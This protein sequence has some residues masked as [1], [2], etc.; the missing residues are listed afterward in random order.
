YVKDDTIV[1]FDDI[2]YSAEMNDAWKT[3]ICDERVT[4]SLNL[5]R[6]GVIFFNPSL[7]KQNFSLYY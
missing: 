1:V 6:I 7:S 3:I 2:N 5:F 4:L